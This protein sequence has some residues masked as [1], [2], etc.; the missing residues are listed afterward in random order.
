MRLQCLA[1][2]LGS[3]FGLVE[4]EQCSA[5]VVSCFRISWPGFCCGSTMR[6][7]F[8]KP[9]GINQSDAPIIVGSGKRWIDSQSFG[10]LMASLVKVAVCDEGIRVVVMNFG[11]I[12]V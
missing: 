10:K 3:L 2:S 4:F 7:P 12:E 6:C 1:I 9:S 5:E 11:K 8:L